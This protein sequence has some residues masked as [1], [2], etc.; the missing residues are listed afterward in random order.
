MDWRGA[1]GATGATGAISKSGTTGIEG[2]LN[3]TEEPGDGGDDDDERTR[4]CEG[5][6]SIP[7]VG[8]GSETGS[9]TGLKAKSKAGSI[10][11]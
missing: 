1:A 6:W 2:S 10:S 5:I 4:Y 7:M 8:E 3:G 9:G 11:G